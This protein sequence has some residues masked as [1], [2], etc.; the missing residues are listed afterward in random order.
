MLPEQIKTCKTSFNTIFDAFIL[1]MK[2]KAQER[3]RER[4]TQN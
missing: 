4:E 3:E 2:L 1:F